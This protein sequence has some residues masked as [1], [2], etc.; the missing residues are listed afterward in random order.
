MNYNGKVTARKPGVVVIRASIG[1]ASDICVV[2]VTQPVTGIRL[3]D[4]ELTIADG[5]KGM[6]TTAV[7][8]E[9]AS[10]YSISWSS[11]DTDVA[12]V[13]KNGVITATGTGRAT[14]TAQVD[15]FSDTCEVT[16]E[17][18]RMSMHRSKG[19]TIIMGASL[20][21]GTSGVSWSS[22]DPT[23]AS[24]DASGNVKGIA[25][26]NTVITATAANYRKT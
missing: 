20:A 9:D 24:V 25:E 21:V 14:I 17:N 18:L 2:F 19:S 10:E 1:S 23:V 7:S 12:Q 3:S 22:S 6:L 4:D 26:G 8:P 5:T 16:V 15:S 11:S 13:D